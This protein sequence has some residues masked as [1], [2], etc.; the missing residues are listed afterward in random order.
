MERTQN[1][2]NKSQQQQH[3]QERGDHS[4]ERVRH[5]EELGEENV[6]LVDSEW[7]DFERALRY[8][9]HILLQ[10]NFKFNTHD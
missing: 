3:S 1:N 7:A 4:L 2:S 9:I 8:A 5:D 6:E 10:L